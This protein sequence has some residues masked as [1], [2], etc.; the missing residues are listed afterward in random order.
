MPTLAIIQA[1]MSSTRFPGKVL[2]ELQKKPLLQWMLERVAECSLVDKVIIA[3]S[4]GKDDDPISKWCAENNYTCYRGDLE[5]VLSRFYHAAKH[6][7]AQTIVRL[8]ADCPVIDA[9]V[10]DEHIRFYHSHHYDYVSNGPL[11]TYPDGMGVEVFS[12]LAL[13]R[14]YQEAK[15]LSEKEHV[16]AYIYKHPEIFTLF[17]LKYKK[18]YSWIRITV[19]YPEDFTLVKKI[20]DALQ[21]TAA[22]FS[23]EDIIDYIEKNPALLKL[24]NKHSPN[25]GYE[26]SLLKD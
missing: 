24:N 5:N 21:P 3:T 25:E 26:L 11:M 7:N 15:L 4:T 2:I 22:S 18:D 17:N 16:T 10:I 14:T 1:R 6:F 12:F 19:D 8:T 13:E 20:V 23:L 9:K